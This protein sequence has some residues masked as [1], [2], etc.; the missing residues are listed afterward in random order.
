[1]KRGLETTVPPGVL[2]AISN[3]VI[4]P[5]NL[6]KDHISS[7]TDLGDVGGL[8]GSGGVDKKRRNLSK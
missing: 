8:D 3:T 4:S 1:M 7:A 5:L 6:T 2:Y